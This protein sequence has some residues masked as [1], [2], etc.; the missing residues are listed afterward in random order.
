MRR[1]KAHRALT[2]QRARRSHGLTI[3]D[4]KPDFGRTRKV[5][6][7]KAIPHRL[8]ATDSPAM[9]IT[10]FL[11]GNA[12][13]PNA[14]RADGRSAV[15]LAAARGYTDI[16]EILVHR[17]ATPRNAN[18]GGGHRGLGH[19]APRHRSGPRAKAAGFG[20]GQ[21]GPGGFG[22]RH[23]RPSEKPR[24]EVNG[25]VAP[26]GVPTPPSDDDES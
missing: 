6:R 1:V 16:V 4:P 23:A 10:Q 22:H 25:N 20:G 24:A 18:A 19:D 14:K 17:G 7:I 21:K 26:P 12:S 5:R 15:E 9:E 2:A 13:D 8:P 3:R 11:A